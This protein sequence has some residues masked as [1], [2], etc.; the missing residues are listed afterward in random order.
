MRWLTFSCLICA[1][2]L[3]F[4]QKLLEVEVAIAYVQTSP[5]FLCCTRKRDVPFF[6]CSKGNRRR[7]HAGNGCWNHKKLLLIPKVDLKLL[8]TIIGTGLLT[9]SISLYRPYER[10][11]PHSPTGDQALHE[12]SGLVT[13]KR[14]K[15]M[16]NSKLSFDTKKWSW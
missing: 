9:S 11:P 12:G 2:N 16:E 15:T 1:L 3:Y 14:V 10:I 4:A 5:F 8:S 13:Y 6:A 7:L